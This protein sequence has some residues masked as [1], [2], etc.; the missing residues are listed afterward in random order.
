M[1]ETHA[2]Q[3]S[4]FWLE[5]SKKNISFNE[6][7]ELGVEIGKWVDLKYDCRW[8]EFIGDEL[9]FNLPWYLFDGVV[10]IVISKMMLI[11]IN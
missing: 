9:F 11:E 2:A 5:R 7:Y 4:Q 8:N 6:L 10:D 3:E 1:P